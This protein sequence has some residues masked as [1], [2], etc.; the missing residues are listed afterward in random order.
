MKIVPQAQ[1][2][3]GKLLPTITMAVFHDE[4]DI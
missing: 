1:D 2:E 4:I 3:K